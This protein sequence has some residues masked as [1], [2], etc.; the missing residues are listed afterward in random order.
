MEATEAPR[1]SAAGV[2][3]PASTSGGGGDDASA[4]MARVRVRL[5]TWES[6]FHRAHGRQPNQEDARAAPGVREMYGEYRS[7]KAIVEKENARSGEHRATA[8]AEAK[9]APARVARRATPLR[10]ASRGARANHATNPAAAKPTR[11]SAMTLL[12]PAADDSSDDDDDDDVV[13][14]TPVKAAAATRVQPDRLA[15]SPARPS[16]AAAAAAPPAR[17]ASAWA[18]P[19]PKPRVRPALATPKS[20]ELA[21]P[22]LA[23]PPRVRLAQR[24]SKASVANPF[25]RGAAAPASA[26]FARDEPSSVAAAKAERTFEPLLCDARGALI[27]EVRVARAETVRAA[28]RGEEPNPSSK[29]PRETT[30]S[31]FL[32]TDATAAPAKIPVVMPA[33]PKRPKAK[34]K[35]PPAPTYATGKTK[36]KTKTNAKRAR[37][38]D[39][40]DED[41]MLA[42]MEDAEREDATDAAATAPATAPAPAPEPEE[43][44]DAAEARAAAAAKRRREAALAKRRERT[45]AREAGASDGD[46]DGD[47]DFD[48]ANEADDFEI[49]LSKRAT[50]RPSTAAGVK[51]K[52]EPSRAASSAA[53][54]AEKLSAALASAPP[55]ASGRPTTGRERAEARNA[56]VAA[57]LAASA[58]PAA[59]RRRPAAKAS[60]ESAADWRSRGGDEAPDAPPPLPARKKR[61]ASKTSGGNFVKTNLRKTYKSRPVRGGAKK[62]AGASHRYGGGAQNWRKGA[63]RRK[64]APVPGDDADQSVWCGGDWAKA[65][66]GLD[67]EEARRAA[68]EAEAEEARRAAREAA[69]PRAAAYAAAEAAR[70]ERLERP[71]SATLEAAKRAAVADPSEANLLEVL[72]LAF[73]HAAFRPGQLEVIARVLR[74]GSSLALL[75]TGAGKSLT[76]QLPALLFPGLTLVVSPLL[77]LMADQ[78]R[79]LPP[80]LPGAALRSDQSNAA[81]FATLDRMRA[82]ELKVLFVSPERLLNE[83]FLCDLRGVPGGVS[84]AVVD[85]AHCVSEWSHNFRPAYHRL[86]RVLRD[87]V[88]LEGP[89]LALTATATARTEASLRSTLG[90]PAEGA[91]R[92]D[93]IRP[94]LILSAM[95]VPATAREATLLHLLEREPMRGEGSAIVYCAFQNQAETTAAYLQAR[96]V[97]AKAYHAGQEPQERQETQRKFFDGSIRVVVATVAF[98][99][100]LDKP[101]VR[102]V[103]NFSLP[104]SPEAYV[105]Q[106][107]RAGRDGEPAR[108]VSFIDPS[109]FRRLRS[110]C[111]S[112]GI[113][114]TAVLKL[115]ERVFVKA[116]PKETTE[117]READPGGVFARE[118]GAEDERGALVGA[119]VVQK[120]ERELDVRGEVIET[121]LSCLEL[122]DE[123][124][125]DPSAPSQP[126]IRVLPDTRA[127]CEMSFHGASPTALATRCPLVAAALAISGKPKQGTYT[128]SVARAAREMRSGLDEVGDQLKALSA[129]GEAAYRLL[130]RA[131]GYELLR[132][133]PKDPRPLAVALANHLDAVERSAVRKLDTVYAALETAANAEDDEAQGAV[134]RAALERYLGAGGGGGDDGRSRDE[135]A[136]EDDALDLGGA[137]ASEA[138]RDLV[139]D[140]RELLTHRTGG[141]AGG[142]GCMSARAVARVLHGLG[143]PAFPAQEWRR[144]AL[145]ERHAEVDFAVVKRVAE[146]ELLA[147]RGI[148]R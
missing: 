65:G 134:L 32:E 52:R 70:R 139:R 114:R 9:P 72:R 146:E 63:A 99:M 33:S 124:K 94:N 130:D 96:G 144:N 126:L 47:S 57:A 98:G 81:L 118:D 67:A 11:P 122:W 79:G 82:G 23:L 91:F 101:D 76:Y 62:S 19:P 135:K 48:V 45:A 115:L 15:K 29:A 1:G 39:D 56:A 34:P 83:R 132:P 22:S 13:D 8:R 120:L 125:G 108:C 46:S 71:G 78:I 127:T 143:S 44:L 111:H 58:K 133:P 66:E 85:E 113:D 141:K 54:A 59:A 84:L 43:D 119:L 28:G 14:A 105:Q 116:P 49:G 95:R 102:A 31:D 26:S 97:S 110:L 123:M 40:P 51:R 129:N 73:G 75:P 103:I 42:A 41:E 92:N 128:F 90:I 25:G 55:K 60:D 5:K 137:I 18:S 136:D 106:A 93:A 89:V 6:D 2:D 107:G 3:A 10:D 64:E 21:A 37:R 12:R 87:R 112:D 50:R 109:D 20:P 36:T 16:P 7:L 17:P 53:E 38:A 145:W 77:A 69:R 121:V 117:A 74:G 24:P 148:K 142:A 138:P 131:V 104:R 30:L 88:R 147:M 80:A 4:R 140:V 100:G 27:A 35:P 61:P 86:G 68:R